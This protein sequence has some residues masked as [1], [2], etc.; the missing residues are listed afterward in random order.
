MLRSLNEQTPSAVPPLYPRKFCDPVHAAPRRARLAD[1]P[2]HR[3]PAERHRR[4]HDE[5]H[6]RRRRRRRSHRDVG[7][8]LAAAG[9][10]AAAP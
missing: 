6:A 9:A 4:Q 2:R 8:A 1:Q 3:L 10:G 7:R 5:A